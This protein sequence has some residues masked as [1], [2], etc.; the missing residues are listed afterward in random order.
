M[1]NPLLSSH[2]PAWQ[3]IRA[4]IG[5]ISAIDIPAL[6]LRSLREAED[7]LAC[8]GFDWEDPNHR[9]ELEELRVEAI[10]FIEEELLS[11]EPNLTL[12]PEVRDQTDVR[13]LLR[14]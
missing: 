9:V 8:Y 1:P 4:L 11:D 2:H 5:G 7:F 13:Q 14:W 10:T 3:T 6:S 12:I